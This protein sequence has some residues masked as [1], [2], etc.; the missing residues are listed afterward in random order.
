[1]KYCR[2]DVLSAVFWAGAVLFALLYALSSFTLSINGPE[3]NLERIA[4]I[5]PWAN[6]AS[7]VAILG[8]AV[9]TLSCALVPALARML[10]LKRALALFIGLV[11]APGAFLSHTLH[12]LGPW[13]LYG[14]RIGPDGTR[15]LFCDSSFLQGQTMAIVVLIYDG[16]VHREFKVLAEAHGDWPR[17]WASVI[18]PADAIESYGQ[19]Y[20]T[21]QQW[22]VGVRYSNE[23]YLAYDLN[24]KVQVLSPITQLS[25]FVLLGRNSRPLREDVQATL[26]TMRNHEAHAQSTLDRRHLLAS[27]SAAQASSVNRLPASTDGSTQSP[28]EDP[29]LA[30]MVQFWLSGYPRPEALQVGVQ[31]KN[32][33]V[34]R[35]AHQLLQAHEE[36]LQRLQESSEHALP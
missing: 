22:I 14:E 3:G 35:I 13:T 6:Q 26:T 2:R 24:K 17:S 36:I 5:Q 9:I 8:V 33:H 20:L 30:P 31:S 15:Y 19:L 11:L 7:H 16:P 25:P 10:R 27:L 18:R 29:S 34:V 12:N 4:I 21:D 1:M 23:A 28:L 32:P